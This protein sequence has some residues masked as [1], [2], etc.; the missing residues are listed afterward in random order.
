MKLRINQFAQAFSQTKT[1]TPNMRL[2][3]N[4]TTLML[5]H[6]G[7]VLKAFEKDTMNVRL[8]NKDY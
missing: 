7:S 2:R 6:G 1:K 4:C 5:R 8:K 3:T